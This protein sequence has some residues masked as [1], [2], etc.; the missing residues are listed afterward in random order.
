[1]VTT[2]KKMLLVSLSIIVAGGM[3]GIS[4]ARAVPSTYAVEVSM[5]VVLWILLLI[6]YRGRKEERYPMTE[7]E[8]YIVSR[9]SARKI[10]SGTDTPESLSASFNTSNSEGS[11][12]SPT[13]LS[14]EICETKAQASD[15]GL[16]K[17]T[18]RNLSKG[19]PPMTIRIPIHIRVEQEKRR[20]SLNECE[21]PVG[22][23]ATKHCLRFPDSDGKRIK[24]SI[25]MSKRTSVTFLELSVEGKRPRKVKSIIYDDASHAIQDGKN[26][27]LLLPRDVAV[28]TKSLNL[29][30][31]VSSVKLD[32]VNGLLGPRNVVSNVDLI[33]GSETVGK[34]QVHSMNRLSL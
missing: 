4:C 3:I 10:V 32:C 26:T 14:D 15:A 13:M 28:V 34:G 16:S 6:M 7:E 29:L 25:R 12:Q 9:C 23:K 27:F 1:M 11:A 22:A 5:A 31:K 19:S 30:C 2:E 20:L 33:N 24:Y 8:R 18:P 21:E 17:G